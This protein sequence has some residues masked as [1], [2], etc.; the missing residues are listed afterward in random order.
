[1]KKVKDGLNLQ[2][3]ASQKDV[4]RLNKEFYGRFNYPWP[5]M[6]FQ[7][8]ADPSFWP[9]HLNQ[10]IGHWQGDRIPANPKIWVGGCG[11]NQ[12][13]ITALKY[14]E[15]HVL[16][17]DISLP[18]LETSED[19]ALQLGVENLELEEK[20]LNSAT[21]EE[22][23]DFVICTGVIHHNA[24]PAVPLKRL[25]AGLKPGGVMELMV[26]NFYHMLLQGAF[27]TAIRGLCGDGAS[28]SMEEELKTT[29]ELI[30]SFPERNLMA[31]FLNQFANAYESDLADNL[32]QPVMHSYTIE[33]F[34]EMLDEAGLELLLPCVNQFDRAD[35]RLS[36]NM[37][38][39]DSSL[40]KR[41]EAMEDAKRWQ[42]SNLLLFERSPMLWFYV[43][44]KDSSFS[45]KSERQ[46][47]EEFL[48][49]RFEKKSTNVRLFSRDEKGEYLEQSQHQT[50]P[51]PLST[52]DHLAKLVFNAADPAKTMKEIFQE[53]QLEPTFQ[54]INRVRVNLTTSAFPYLTSVK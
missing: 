19:S 31:D 41:Y 24:D 40:Q 46:V 25:A 15:A 17:T 4:D 14:P 2:L 49:N 21:Y 53:L 30:R 23:F 27:Q 47:C 52:H 39:D 37:R 10:D 35:N 22:E 34:V 36:W 50:F 33:T 42:L 3:A 9:C 51:G 1:M 28:M 38:F 8:F 32:L 20:S 12:S 54:N 26:Y 5:P 48:A 43:Q 16:G 18:S 13:V 45:R 44:R 29:R 6:T 11:T 7:A